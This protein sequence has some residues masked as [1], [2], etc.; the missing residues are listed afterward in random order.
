M[1]QESEDRGLD[2][3]LS[4]DNKGR[5]V[6]HHETRSIGSFQYVCESVYRVLSE[7]RSVSTVVT[8]AEE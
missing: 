5:W 4:K 6:K 1:E 7:S 3:L 2:P 8:E